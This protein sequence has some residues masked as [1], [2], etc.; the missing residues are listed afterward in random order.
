MHRSP[1]HATDL[2]SSYLYKL[3]GDNLVAPEVQDHLVSIVV[4]TA[5]T[6]IQE[7][8]F[9]VTEHLAWHSPDLTVVADPAQ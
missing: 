6:N 7:H 1:L 3:G 9:C 5:P 4:R 2:N 8:P